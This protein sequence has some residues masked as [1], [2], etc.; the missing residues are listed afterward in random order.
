MVCL[1]FLVVFFF[2]HFVNFIFLCIF[3]AFSSEKYAVTSLTLILLYFSFREEIAKFLTHY[4]RAAKEL[5]PEHVS[6]L[7]YVCSLFCLELIKDK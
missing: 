5:R 3:C 4:A 1:F 2:F 7:P 6:K